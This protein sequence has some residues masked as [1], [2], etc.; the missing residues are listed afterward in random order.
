MLQKFMD[1]IPNSFYYARLVFAKY[2]FLSDKYCTYIGIWPRF[3]HPYFYRLVNT[4]NG[5]LRAPSPPIPA[6]LIYKL[7]RMS[8]F[9]SP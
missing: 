4:Q 8:T 1:K 7:R 5:T 3:A 2:F 9:V 6:L